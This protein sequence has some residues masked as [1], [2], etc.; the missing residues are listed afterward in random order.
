MLLDGFDVTCMY[1]VVTDVVWAVYSLGAAAVKGNT[2]IGCQVRAGVFVLLYRAHLLF[3]GWC[4]GTVC[5]KLWAA[6]AVWQQCGGCSK[7]QQQVVC[8]DIG[9]AMLCCA[10][11]HTRAH[12]L[13]PLRNCSHPF[14]PPHTPKHTPSNQ[15]TNT[16]S[17]H[18]NTKQA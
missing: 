8:S 9:C 14:T 1:I 12:P 13:T 7:Q 6:A 5:V 18:I 16:N 11:P 3:A 4:V 10:A 15:H 2:G 17:H